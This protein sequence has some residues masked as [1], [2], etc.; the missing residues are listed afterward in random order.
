MLH[1]ISHFTGESIVKE[2]K[3]KIIS[4]ITQG[5]ELKDDLTTTGIS[6][7]SLVDPEEPVSI[8]RDGQLERE[9]DGAEV[10][11]MEAFRKK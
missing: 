8:D 1:C 10:I 2:A 9:P 4:Q 3:D 5:G 6:D 7:A 11:D